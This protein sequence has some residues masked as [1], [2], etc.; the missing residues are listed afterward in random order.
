MYQSAKHYYNYVWVDTCRVD[1]GV[2][3]MEFQLSMF[4]YYEEAGVCLTFLS[5]VSLPP[6]SVLLA[7][8]SQMVYPGMDAA[9]AT[10]AWFITFYASDWSGIGTPHEFGA[11]YIALITGMNKHYLWEQVDI[12]RFDLLRKASVA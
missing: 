10:G 9:R 3:Q 2:K 11:R 4:R 1:K 6:D 8:I 5:D 12:T 7:G